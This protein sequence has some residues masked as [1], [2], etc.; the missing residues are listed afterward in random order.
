M[1]KEMLQSE[2]EKRGLQEQVIFRDPVSKKEVFKYILS[3]DMGASVLKRVD[4]FKTIYSNKTFD[5]MSCKKPI[6]LAIEGIS[7]DLIED[8]DCGIC[9]EPE[10]AKDI[11]DKIKEAINSN[12]MFDK[13]GE[14]GYFYAKERFD[15][16][17]LADT[18]ISEI[19]KN[20]K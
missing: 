15:R 9:V 11:S 18:Y 19:E 5:Y 13:M 8:A 4:T 6:L 7:K 10:N 16:N 1:Q 17:K 3:S 2:V 20:F 12:A 14:N